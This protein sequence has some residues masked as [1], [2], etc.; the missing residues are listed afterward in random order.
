LS[1]EEDKLAVPVAPKELL[2]QP[3]LKY[4]TYLV[5]KYSLPRGLKSVKKTRDPGI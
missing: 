2:D 4:M 5:G 1:S 3:Q